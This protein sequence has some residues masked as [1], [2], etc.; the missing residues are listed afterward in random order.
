MIQPRGALGIFFVQQAVV[1]LLV[2]GIAEYRR[3]PQLLGRVS[4]HLTLELI[5]IQLRHR[6]GCDR[7]DGVEATH[8]LLLLDLLHSAVL[9]RSDLIDISQHIVNVS[10]ISS[11]GLLIEMVK[12]ILSHQLDTLRRHKGLLAVDIMYLFVVDIRLCLHRLDIVH[13][14][15]Q[16][17]LV[18]DRV[19]DRIGVQLIAEGLFSG[20]EMRI[21]HVTGVC[22]EDRRAGE[23]E[24]M[25]LFEVLDDR[26]VHIAELAA[27]AFV[28][29]DDD[30]LLIHRMTLVLI[31]E[32][33]ELLDCRDDDPRVVVLELLFQDRGRGIAVGGALFK[34][35]IFL[36]RLVVEVFS[37][38]NE[39][40]LVD[41]G[42][43]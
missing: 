5:I 38:H 26:G 19:N 3:D 10:L 35:V 14:E 6:D 25:I 11:I 39:Q 20:G 36:H 31:D 18:I 30:M 24:H 28:K 37:V 34:A 1:D 40:H 27:V 7:K 15:G 16:N 41:A 2:G 8:S 12:D 42:Q 23:A 21:L 32:G 13:A 33:R 43:L 17:I 22:G 9:R 4:I 29:D